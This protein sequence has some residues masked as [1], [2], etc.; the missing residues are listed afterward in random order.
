LG[1]VHHGCLEVV[2]KFPSLTLP[3]ASGGGYIDLPS[4]PL[5]GRVGRG[6]ATA[7]LCQETLS[8]YRSAWVTSQGPRPAQYFGGQRAITGRLSRIRLAVEFRYGGTR[9]RE[10]CVSIRCTRNS[11]SRPSMASWRSANSFTR[12]AAKSASSGGSSVTTQQC[13]QSRGEVGQSG[14]PTRGRPPRRNEDVGGLFPG[15]IEQVKQAA[16][17]NSLRSASSIANAPLASACGTDAAS[18]ARLAITR[19]PAALA[20][21]AAKWLLPEPSG[22]NQ[23]HG[24]RRPIGPAVDQGERGLVARSAEKIPRGRSFPDDRA[25]D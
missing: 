24:A 9:C 20:Q 13:A 6:R 22:P 17:S 3:Q 18:I 19:P 11:I 21:I 12:T 7:I 10:S 25:R 4:P 5:A 2:A 14:R 16:S 8:S 23:R 15:E 1:S